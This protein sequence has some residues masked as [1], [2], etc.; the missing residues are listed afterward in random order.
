VIRSGIAGA[1]EGIMTLDQILG[2]MSA[3]NSTNG[4]DAV[5][6]MNVA[7]INQLFLQQYA[8][9][10]PGDATRR[11]R[12]SY[13]SPPG[14]AIVDMELGPMSL[15]IQ[16]QDLAFVAMVVSGRL[17]QLD[18]N[19]GLSVAYQLPPLVCKLQGSFPLSQVAGVIESQI[20]MI[21]A[22]LGSGTYQ[23]DVPGLRNLGPVVVAL[24]QY[25]NQAQPRYVLGGVQTTTAGTI[26]P[27]AFQFALQSSGGEGAL[28]LLIK[29]TGSDGTAGPL[30]FYP[31]PDGSTA[32]LILSNRIVMQD[33]LAPAVNAALPPGLDSLNGP[34]VFAL[35]ASPVAPGTYQMNAT[36]ASGSLALGPCMSEF[37]QTI[38][39][40]DAS[41][42][43]ADLALLPMTGLLFSISYSLGL[44]AYWANTWEQYWS[45]LQADMTRKVVQMEMTATMTADYSLAM[46]GDD[47]TFSGTPTVSVT[48]SGTDQDGANAAAKMLQS[49]FTTPFSKIACPAI[50]TFALD[51]LLFP[52]QDVLSF[53]TPEFPADLLLVGQVQPSVTVTPVQIALTAGQTAQFQSSVASASWNVEGDGSI[54]ASGLYTAPAAVAWPE[55]VVVAATDPNNLGSTGCAIITLTPPPASEENSLVLPPPATV[56]PG[57][58]FSF[59]VTNTS[60]ATVEA[61]CSISPPTAGTLISKSGQWFLSQINASLTVSASYWDPVFGA[62]LTGSMS[63][64][65]AGTDVVTVTAASTSL[66]LGST[67]PQATT[68]TAV[69]QKA[70]QGA[71][72]AWYVDPPFGTVILPNPNDTTQ[73][74]YTLPQSS[75][76]ANPGQVTVYA[77]HLGG[78]WGQGSATIS[79]SGSTGH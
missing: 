18:A 46:N 41:G 43:K 47:V 63:V 33:G 27:T 52:A 61:N 31:I 49:E 58:S 53:T 50:S 17:I 32:S 74:T 12:F 76:V 73:A 75:S 60:G 62:L 36:S 35:S 39:S 70:P 77:Y 56:S 9:A 20:G 30:S 54:S 65:V 66:T 25:F 38:Y 16:N 10:G 26:Q 37:G 4:W 48:A 64:Q 7:Q 24:T 6:A 15:S 69:S 11:A 23:L 78:S 22:D 5:C 68:L 79:I 40:C 67:P 1:K 3:G 71:V 28:L 14:T 2:A 51:N 44:E 34:L 57:S 45:V 55:V 21:V 29:T 72:F 13:S 8:L 42:N 19:G 59:V